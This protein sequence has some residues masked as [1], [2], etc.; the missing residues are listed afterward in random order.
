MGWG[1]TN[2]PML[3]RDKNLVDHFNHRKSRNKMEKRSLVESGLKPASFR[4]GWGGGRLC[5]QVGG[6]SFS[7]CFRDRFK[8]RFRIS[9]RLRF[10][11]GFLGCEAGINFR[12]IR[13]M[14]LMIIL[15]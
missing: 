10:G 14:N 12:G 5:R 4:H 13:W 11:F 7:F 9:F 2:Q 3:H 8:L 15:V 6:G 1:E